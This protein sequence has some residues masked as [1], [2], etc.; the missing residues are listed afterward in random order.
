M[1]TMGKTGFGAGRKRSEWQTQRSPADINAEVEVDVRG[2][3]REV[4]LL[5]V[6]R[7]SSSKQQKDEH[8]NVRPNQA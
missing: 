1:Q 3:L 2:R 7:L 4:L 6:A 5:Q 8:N